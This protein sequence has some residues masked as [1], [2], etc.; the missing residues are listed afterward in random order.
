MLLYRALRFGQPW[1]EMELAYG[2][3]TCALGIRGQKWDS[4]MEAGGVAELSTARSCCH[5]V[6]IGFPCASSS[7]KRSVR[8]LCDVYLV[9]GELRSAAEFQ[10]FIR[11]GMDRAK[12]VLL[13]PVKRNLGLGHSKTV[14]VFFFFF[15]TAAL[16]ALVAVS[17]AASGAKMPSCGCLGKWTAYLAKGLSAELLSKHFEGIVSASG[18]M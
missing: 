15:R 12:N 7:P 17:V 6:D 13:F 3:R 2:S 18:C 1:T 5:T 14:F 8:V 10:A 16:L 11:S 4:R 9:H